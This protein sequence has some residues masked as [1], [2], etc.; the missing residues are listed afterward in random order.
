MALADVYDA[1]VSERPYKKAF[2]HTEAV[3]IIQDGKG[4]QF[5][6]VLTDVFI[7]IIS[8]DCPKT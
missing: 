5:D 7:T 2:S 6:P 8:Q 3:K 4:T 1:L